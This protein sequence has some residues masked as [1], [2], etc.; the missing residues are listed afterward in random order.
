MQHLGP[1]VIRQVGR[2]ERLVHGRKEDI[3][4]IDQACCPG[5]QLPIFRDQHVGGSGAQSSLFQVS[6][7][8]SVA[9]VRHELCRKES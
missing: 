2:L 5:L 9:G 4:V 7:S 3:V 6:S 1:S 8:I